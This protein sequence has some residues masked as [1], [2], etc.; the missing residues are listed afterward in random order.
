MKIAA[1]TWLSLPGGGAATS[2]LTN[3][4]TSS[5]STSLSTSLPPTPSTPTQGAI[6]PSSQQSAGEDR[7]V[8]IGLGAGIP[9]AVLLIAVIAF[10]G[11]QLKQSNDLKRP[12]VGPQIPAIE[13]M[14]H[15]MR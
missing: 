6:Q 9:L 15:P 8:A 12:T 1:A 7:S 4:P 14:P 10:T 2:T 3:T 5:T 11:W 13:A